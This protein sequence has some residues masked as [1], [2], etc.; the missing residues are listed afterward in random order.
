MATPKIDTF[1][2]KLC[3]LCTVGINGV[4]TCSAPPEASLPKCAN[5]ANCGKPAFIDPITDTVHK[6]CRRACLHLNKP[7]QPVLCPKNS[8]PKCANFANC[9]KNAYVD[10]KTG[11][12]YDFC[13]RTC[14][15]RNRN[16]PIVL[17][18]LAFGCSENHSRHFCKF[19]KNNNSNHKSADCPQKTCDV[20]SMER[21]FHFGN[22]CP[23][24][25]N[26]SFK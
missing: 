13:R 26:V 18:C 19:C 9:G 14:L 10:P 17:K 5:F 8:L 22:L 1:V 11:K 3:P 4:V 21:E 24:R 23:G 12:V 15:D 7:E 16:K 25:K 6:L 20:C 2:F